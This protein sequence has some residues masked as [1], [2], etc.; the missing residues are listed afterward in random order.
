M[1]LHRLETVQRIPVPLALAWEFFSDARNLSRI[2]PPSMGFQVTSPLPE[3]VY[4]GLIIAYRVRPLLGVP[5]TW[6]TEITQVD[7]QRMFVDEQ[8]IGPYRMWHH[9]HHFRAVDGGVE[10]RDLVHYALPPG[11]GIAHRWMLAP[12]L[13]QIFAYRKQVL[14]STFGALE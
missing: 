5:L 10:V 7:P 3:R 12:R 8:R 4:P 14:E 13:A 9:E 2:T 1:R 6:V 11:G